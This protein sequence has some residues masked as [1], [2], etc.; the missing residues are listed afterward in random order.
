MSRRPTV[1]KW[2]ITA[3]VLIAAGFLIAGASIVASMVMLL[4]GVTS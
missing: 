1:S 4:E 2:D 3:A